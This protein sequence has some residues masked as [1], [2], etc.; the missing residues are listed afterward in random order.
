MGNQLPG[1]SS[2]GTIIMLSPPGAPAFLG[3]LAAP[4]TTG[5]SRA[6]TD[7][8]DLTSQPTVAS[9]AGFTWFRR[10]ADATVQLNRRCAL[11]KGNIRYFGGTRTYRLR[12][13]RK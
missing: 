5:L 7:R 10:A 13:V 11:L 12:Y 1:T 4:I 9:D 6:I 8:H 3:S 2:P